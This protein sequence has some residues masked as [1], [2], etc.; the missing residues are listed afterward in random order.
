MGSLKNNIG[1]YF[2]PFLDYVL[3]AANAPDGFPF[4]FSYSSLAQLAKSPRHFFQYV[5]ERKFNPQPV[6]C[7]TLY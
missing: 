6:C 7:I 4:A 3:G 2:A 5:V 1:A